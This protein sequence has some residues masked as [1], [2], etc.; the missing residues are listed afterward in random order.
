MAARRNP[1]GLRVR[2]SRPCL[3]ETGGDPCRC[4]PGPSWEAWV[5]EKRSGSKISKRFS[6]KG[7]YAAAKNWRSDA[8]GAARRGQLRRPTRKTVREA[9]DEL[10]AG[11]KD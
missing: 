5:Y 9:A 7:A 1:T 8:Q 2:H 4:K 11:M 3:R 10:V 6:G